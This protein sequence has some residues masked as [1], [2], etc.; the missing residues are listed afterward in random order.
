LYNAGIFAVKAEK[1]E[2]GLFL[3]ERF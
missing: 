2:R 1:R 3:D